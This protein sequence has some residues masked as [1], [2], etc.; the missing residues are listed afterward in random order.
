MGRLERIWIKRAHRGPMD[1]VQHAYCAGGQGLVGNVDR[2]RRRQITILERESW[3]RLMAAF[4]ASP[5]PSTRRANLLV[6]GIS[7]ARS[8]GR[9]LRIGTV[10]L[11]IGGEVTPCERMDDVLPGL[12]EA[13]RAEWAGGAF[14]QVLT[15]GTIRVGD[16][17]EWEEGSLQESGVRNQDSAL[18]KAT[19]EEPGT[20]NQQS[21]Q[22]Q[23]TGSSLQ[24]SAQE[25][26]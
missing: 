10:T 11:L 23:A 19:S 16:E 22:G 15:S 21:V 26:S 2:S 9:T 1:A 8:R 5:D 12:Q 3:E 4:S 18:G 13:M 7:L 6:S 24:E 17:V 20:R 25:R 14:A